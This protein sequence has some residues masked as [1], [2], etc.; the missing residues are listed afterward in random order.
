MTRK[1]IITCVLLNLVATP[2]LGSV[3]AQRWVA[4][5]GQ[6]ILS[7][8]G[9]VLMMIWF[10]QVMKSY[11]GQM[12]NSDSTEHHPVVLTGLIFGAGLFAAGWIW[13]LVTSLSLMRAAKNSEVD[14]LK[15]FSATAIKLDE[16]KIMAALGALPQWTR[17]GALISRTFEFADFVAAMKFANA[18]AEIAEAAQHHPDVDIRSNKV[19]LALTT[20]DTGG[21]TEKDF[22]LARRCDALAAQN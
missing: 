20:H 1:R 3:M 10:F 8:A 19:T 22:A 7:L 11:Y 18:V 9:F 6:I 5:I 2:G 21:L 17:S 4:G 12:F 16:T 15:M 14:E 13:S